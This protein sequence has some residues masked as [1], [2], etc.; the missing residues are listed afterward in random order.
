MI[1]MIGIGPFIT[2][3]LIIHAAG[4]PQAMLGWIFGAV[5]AMCDGMI[6]SELA[7]AL[8]RAGGSYQY[9]K[10]IYGPRRFGRMASFLY[11][12]Q[13]TFS[14][15]LSIAS[16][17]VG[18]SLYATYLWPPLASTITTCNLD[19]GIPI[20]G[21]M[22]FGVTITRA[23]GLAICA[24]LL[25]VT[26]TYRRIT[27]VGRL[28]N[29]L[30][31][32]VL[33]TV[34]WVVV[35]GLTHFHRALA[36]DFPANAFRPGPE[37]FTGLGAAMLIATYDY[38]GYYNIAFLGEEAK[39]PGR[40]IPR[41]ILFSILAVATIY[42]VMNISILGVM[43]WRELSATAETNTRTYVISSMM[44]RVYGAL[45]GRV[46]AML[47]MWTAFASI[48]SV[49]LGAARVPYAAALDGNYFR[50]FSHLNPK[51]RFP[52]VSLLVLGALAAFFCLFRLADLI[53]ALVVIR[54]LIQFLLQ[55]IGVIILRVQRP[56]LERPFKIPWFPLPVLFSLTGFLYVLFAR[57]NFLRE[58]R[59]AAVLL[60]LGICVYLLRALRR[61][62]WPMQKAGDAMLERETVLPSGAEIASRQKVFVSHPATSSTPPG[63]IEPGIWGTLRQPLFRGLWI[64]AMVSYTGTWMQNM[65]AGWL[66]TSLSS[67][68]LMISLV[69]AATS[70][71]VFFVALP[72]GALADMVDR[73]K[74]LLVTQS[75]M[76]AAAAILGVLT[77]RG[78]VTPVVLL[79][80][81]FF[82]GLGAVMND[83][84]WQAITPEIVSSECVP[85]AVAI[86]SAAFNIARA[87]GPA[88]G[89]IVIATLNSGAAFLLNAA[90]FFGVIFVLARWRRTPGRAHEHGGRLLA[91]I[92][93][94]IVHVSHD[95]TL[96]A[97]LVRTGVFS[98]FSSALWALLP[99]I[100]REHGSVGYG[101][102]F[103]LMGLGALFGAAL[104]SYFRR[105]CSTDTL[106]GFA[107]VLFAAAS[108][109]AGHVDVFWVHCVV[110]VCA[111]FGWISAVASFNVV[112]Q[113]AAP[114]W[115]RARMLSMYVLV[116]QGGMS[117]GS[118]LWGAI[119]DRAGIPSALT[120]AAAGLVMGLALVPFHSLRVPVR[121]VTMAAQQ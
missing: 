115:V 19:L 75:W 32:G 69:Q 110:F 31:G 3:P 84:A 4:G 93:A 71:A 41:A 105:R 74:L 47:I 63:M 96:K 26:L 119:A 11:V 34:A 79:L 59:L 35:A 36:F 111:G 12:W 25:A 51:G 23:T 50:A 81:T 97:V 107:T 6:W 118:G 21:P 80:F 14:A 85:T 43:P 18:L 82:M 99:A 52:D 1:E 13:L 100:A 22:S 70:F 92:R 72:A 67:S 116:L 101:I 98:F 76:V 39:D 64:A 66:M 5:L 58:L 56:E 112:A 16:G 78:A 49:M 10:E 117:I 86:N 15:P 46:A 120:Y 109:T 106:V 102:V 89:G 53:A 57:R 27:V 33:A 30:W 45:A 38:W 61:G 42:I 114:N 60:V 55:T 37:F 94:G 121:D 40:N 113:T 77:L 68:P 87:V 24:C 44:Q 48:F 65:A 91:S 83:P 28:S 88:L 20:L 7:A 17:C 9:L 8:P 108:F 104:L 29:L 95:A 54:I 73:R 2:I 103:G 90:S 62:E